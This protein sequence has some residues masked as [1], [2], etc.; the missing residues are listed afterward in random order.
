MACWPLLGQSELSVGVARDR[1]D[2]GMQPGD[3]M[4]GV[5]EGDS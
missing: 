2:P 4:A 1:H 5:L 3:F